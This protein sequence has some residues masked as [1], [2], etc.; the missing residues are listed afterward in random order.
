MALAL[1]KLLKD[2]PSG[3]YEAVISLT[4]CCNLHCS[5]CYA[6]SGKTGKEFISLRDIRKIASQLKMLG[7]QIIALSGGE[8][9]MHPDFFKILKIFRSK[10]K[11]VFLATNGYFINEKVARQLKNSRIS[12]VQISIEGDKKVHN[13]IRGNSKS[14][15]MAKNA[16]ILLRKQGVD[17]TLTPTFMKDNLSDIKK[18]YSLAKKIGCDLSIKRQISIGRGNIKK[19]ITAEDYRD[20]YIFGIKKNKLSGGPRIFMHCDPLRNIFKKNVDKS[21]LAGCIAGLGLLYIKQNGE[22]YPCSKMPIKIGNIKKQSL[23]SIWKNSKILK[24]L[25]DRNNL[26]GK[27]GNCNN[28]MICGGCRAA[29]YARTGDL[30]AE[31]PL[32]KDL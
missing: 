11:I 29:A 24:K 17:V 32:C 15:D 19:E 20:L 27:C 25:R 26:N 3:V 7:V 6:N 9:L 23:E 2:S 5:F 16:A 21:I 30:F 31:D 4:N 12:N 1:S 13:L 8:P 22:V 14:Y 10:F 18:I 28:K